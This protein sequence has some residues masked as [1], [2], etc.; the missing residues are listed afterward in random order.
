MGKYKEIGGGNT[1]VRQWRNSL[2][3]NLTYKLQADWLILFKKEKPAAEVFFTYY[4]LQAPP[5]LETKRPITFVFNGGPGASSCYLHVGGL[6]PMRAR[7]HADGTVCPPPASL[8]DNPDS[9]LEFTDLVFIDPVGT[10]FS[11]TIKDG[12]KVPP[13]TTPQPTPSATQA[14]PANSQPTV[15]EELKSASP[16]LSDDKEYYQLNKDLESMGEFIERFISINKL[17]DAPICLAGESYGGYRVAK[18]ARR[19]QEKNGIALHAVVAISPALEWNLLMSTDYEVLHYVDSFC[20]M[21]LAAVHHGKSRVFKKG[22]PI[23]EMRESI[24]QF[25]VN[26]LAPLLVFKGDPKETAAKKTYT[27]AAD[28]LGLDPQL[29]FLSRGRL[30][31]HRFAR[32]LLKSEAKVL[33]FYDASVT[34]LDP[35]AD[36]ESHE[37]PD[38]TLAVSHPTFTSAINQLLRQ[39]AEVKTDRRYECINDEVNNTWKRDEQKHLFDMN[40]GATDDLRYAICM[41][42]YM[43]VLICFGYYDLVTPYFQA[44]RLT[45]QMRLSQEQRTNVHI[46]NFNGGHMFYTWDQSRRDFQSWIKSF[47]S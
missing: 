1:I 25:A 38:A 13:S 11:R 24:E 16:D 8:V 17:W 6:G 44:Y 22:T 27:K 21:S 10:G 34:S 40:V 47:Y 35:F 42:P 43:K 19:L 46:K 41:N 15:P 37:A 14:P 28:Y 23:E 26:E 3:E 20:T 5:N 33:G 36:R 31:F 2:G 32:E 18:L 39:I 29:V 12:E 9:W 4:K 30:R 45:D 7:F